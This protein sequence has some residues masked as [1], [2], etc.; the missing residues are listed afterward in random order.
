MVVADGRLRLRLPLMNDPG[1]MV[2]PAN[3]RA[4]VL[5]G[6]L[7]TRLRSVISDRPKSM[8]LVAGVPFLEIILRQLRV[9]GVRNIVLGT[10]YLAEQI[11][12][13]FRE[14]DQLGLSI[15]YSREQEPLGTGGAVK[16]AEPM[17]GD[18]VLVLNGDSYVNWVLTDLL[19]VYLEKQ[20]T[21]V[22]ALQPVPDVSRYG[23]VAVDDDRRVTEFVEKGVR[24]GAG[25]INAGIYLLQ[26]QLITDL[27][28][29]RPISLEREVF[30]Q[31]LGGKVYGVVSAGD[32]I[33]IGVPADL[34]RAQTLLATHGR[35]GH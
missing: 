27:P 11:E 10:G 17:L 14:G 3:L 26:K 33:D 34:E 1:E 18:P 12:E 7:G 31:L 30:P 13:Y 9:A 29:G 19:Q 35:A 5:C 23:S 28:E 6:G 16:L 8:A 24:I 2:S 22:M 32:F 20:A 25:L 4:F 21:A 15:H